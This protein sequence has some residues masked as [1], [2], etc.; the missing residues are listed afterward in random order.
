MQNAP[1]D[2]AR[3]N[4]IGQPPR[5]PIKAIK[6]NLVSVSIG[7]LKRITH[8]LY[9]ELGLYYVLLYGYQNI[10]QEINIDHKYTYKD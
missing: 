10:L 7:V 1:A 3:T 9:G 2:Y 4:A 8:P 6:Q 5:A